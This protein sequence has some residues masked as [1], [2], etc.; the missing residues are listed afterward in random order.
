MV[1]LKYR[2]TKQD[3]PAPASN[4]SSAIFSKVG[5]HLVDGTFVD[6]CELFGMF[7]NGSDASRTKVLINQGFENLLKP[8]K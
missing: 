5:N 2:L 7:D 4:I 3:T 8:R 1:T 6:F